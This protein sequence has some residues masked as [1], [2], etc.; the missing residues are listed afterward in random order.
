M[1]GRPSAR[2]SFGQ[3]KLNSGTIMGLPTAVLDATFATGLAVAAIRDAT[4]AAFENRM[5]GLARTLGW[6]Q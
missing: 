1:R 2:H 5:K 3:G 4:A 6:H